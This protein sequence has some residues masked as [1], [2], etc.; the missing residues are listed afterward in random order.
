MPVQ[1]SSD[2]NNPNTSA[3]NKTEKCRFCD[4]SFTTKNGLGL[5]IKRAHPVEFN[6]AISVERKNVTWSPEEIRMMA[7]KEAEGLR[8]GVRYINVMLVEAFP[9]RTLDAIKGMRRSQKY[10]SV[11]SSL[12]TTE[13]QPTSPSA[14]SPSPLG[15]LVDGSGVG[16]F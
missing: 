1:P 8:N 13:V 9:E 16:S 12:M 14:P 5:H 6:A 3:L 15:V 11:L 2:P 10:K 4:R 7:S